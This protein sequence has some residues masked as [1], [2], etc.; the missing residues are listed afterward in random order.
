[1]AFATKLFTTLGLVCCAILTSLSTAAHANGNV[2]P[3][4]PISLVIAFPAGT[5]TD[6]IGR[7][8]AS[9]LSQSLGQPVVVENKPGGNATIAARYVAKAKPDGYTIF[10]TTNTSHSA[11][12][13]LVKDAGYDPI[14]DFSPIGRIGNIPFVLIANNKLG[15]SKVQDLVSMAKQNPGKLTYASGNATGIL[16]GAIFAS[17]AGIDLLHIP[18]KGSPAALTDLLGGRIDVMFNDLSSSMPYIESKKVKALA[19]TSAKPSAIAPEL[20]PMEAAG[21]RDFDLSAWMGFFGPANMDPEITNRLNTAL[22][23]IIEKP[24]VYEKLSKMGFDAFGSKPDEF[25]KFV[26]TQLT[27]WG[28]MIKEGAIELQ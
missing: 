22:N 8:F 27:L 16:A 17:R 21:V 2:Y 5:V 12:P 7:I 28:A 11:S 4:K 9:E 14:K 25:G 20:E 1:M 6:S 19:V 23:T 15:V 18:Y 3:N 26:A 24:A 13:W 10:I